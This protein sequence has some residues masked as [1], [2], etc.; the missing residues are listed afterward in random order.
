MNKLKMNKIAFVI[1]FNKKI[2]MIII[3]KLMNNKSNNNKL[4]KMQIIMKI[5]MSK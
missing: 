1:S 4:I 2:I 5:I 3:I